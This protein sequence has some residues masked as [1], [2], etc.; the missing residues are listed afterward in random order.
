M[1]SKNRD[2]RMGAPEESVKQG[3]PAVKPDQ[4]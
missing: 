1:G 2:N 3:K 4:V